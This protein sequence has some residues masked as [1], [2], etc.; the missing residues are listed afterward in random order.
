MKRLRVISLNPAVLLFVASSILLFSCSK[1][2]LLIKAKE[3]SGRDLMRSIYFLDGTGTD[4][5][6]PLQEL[7]LENLFS[8]EEVTYIRSHI[9]LFLEQ[10]ENKNPGIFESFKADMCSGDHL[11]IKQSLARNATLIHE[12]AK[13]VNKED[14]LLAKLIAN[15]QKP[16]ASLIN[17]H[18]PQAGISDL[19]PS[20]IKVVLQ[21]DEFKN[22]IKEYF[23]NLESKIDG[24]SGRAEEQLGLIIFAAAVLAF[25]A[26]AV[27]VIY[28]VWVLNAVQLY[29]Y[30]DVDWHPIKRGS[31]NSELLMEQ[32]VNS[33]AINFID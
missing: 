28:V 2:S 33:I 12:T 8:T 15:G 22:N 29:H 32:I 3:L 10:I 18:F 19:S 9:D 31:G 21:S 26:I 17:A 27:A 1:D 25:A 20:E 30:S 11:V 6:E 13:N 16:L 23:S 24:K 14:Q 5:I 4:F 7:K